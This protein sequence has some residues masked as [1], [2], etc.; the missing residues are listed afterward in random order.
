MHIDLL[1]ESRSNIHKVNTRLTEIRR[2]AY[3]L[4]NTFMDSV[5]II[6]K[7]T[8]GKDCQELI[9]TCFIFATEF[10]QRSLLYMDSNR[11]QM[12]NLKLTKLA[13][14]WVSFICDDC[15]ASDRRTFRWAVL[16]LEFAM[17]MTRG[18][19]ILAL[20]EEE[21]ERIRAKRRALGRVLETNNEA[22]R[23][24][25]YLSASATNVTV[26]WQQGQFVG[27]GTF[28]NVYA[29]MNLDTGHLMAVKEIRLQ[30]PKLIPTIAESIREEMRVL[31]VLDHPNVVSYHGIEVH[32][33]RVYIFMEFCSG[34]SLANL[35]EHG[36]IEEEEVI[37]VYALQLLEG[38]AYLHESGIAHRDIK[39]ENILLDH[40]GI[41]KYVDFGAAK[42][43]ARQGRTMAADLH[44]TKPNKSMTGTP[45][46]M[47]PE[48][49]KGENPGKAG[50]VDIWSLGCVILEM[51]TGRRP[52]ANLDN[53]WAIMYNIA[54][55]NPPQ[56]P[57]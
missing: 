52:W 9:Q 48:V 17:G 56:L 24:L 10:G 55:G 13:L 42:L 45:M 31:E 53:E 49:I 28:G 16:A 1:Q 32:R 3:K 8:Q 35:L 34:G 41:I 15:V 4:S 12:N 37:M 11:R 2:V 46:Y 51:A 21:Y 30:D 19:H 29:A 20:G 57:T 25:A 27:G 18:R 22:D 33:D 43:I 36:R 5:E 14:D 47:S 38:L 50:A 39:P 44:A 23:S 26:R 40:N 6:R 7:Q 54:Q